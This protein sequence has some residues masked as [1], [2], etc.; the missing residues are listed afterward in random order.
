MYCWFSGRVNDRTDI[1]VKDAAAPRSSVTLIGL[2]GAGKSFIGQKLAAALDYRY[3]DTDAC[4]EQ[5]AGMGLQQL[6]STY[7][8]EAF[9]AREERIVL[10]LQEIVRCVICPGGSVVYSEK[11]MNF[12]QRCSWI[13]FLDASLMQIQSHIA[14]APERGIVDSDLDL[15]ALAHRRR[16]LYENYSQIRI[17]AQSLE[18]AAGAVAVIQEALRRHGVPSVVYYPKPLHRQLAFRELGHGDSDFPETMKASREVLSLPFGPYFADTETV[19]QHLSL[20]LG[21]K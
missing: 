13:I 16:A 4:I 2:P 5:E 9:L 20:A 12:L 18:T 14:H 11:A 7:G 1:F 17:P 6:L 21:R 8:R 15:A 10:S 3:I 19:A